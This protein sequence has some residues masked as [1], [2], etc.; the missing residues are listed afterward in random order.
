MD[1]ELQEKV[2]ALAEEAKNKGQNS[3]AIVLFTLSGAMLGGQEGPYG[4]YCQEFAM[5]MHKMMTEGRQ[6]AMN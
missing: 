3:A 2:N 1:K 6:A 4:A 5:M